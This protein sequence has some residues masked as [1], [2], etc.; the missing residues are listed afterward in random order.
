MNF[1]SYLTIGLI[2]YAFLIFNG[3]IAPPRS[4]YFSIGN[5]IDK[6]DAAFQG[7]I[8]GKACGDHHRFHGRVPVGQV[9]DVLVFHRIK[10]S[11][12]K[13]HLAPG[14]H[15][16]LFRNWLIVSWFFSL[17]SMLVNAY[18]TGQGRSPSLHQVLVTGTG[19][20]IYKFVVAILLT[21]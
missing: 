15:P 8:P 1:F 4:E 17:P 21:P 9:L 7:Y 20:Y 6:P 14:K 11:P 13:K 2:S 5:G 12:A 3:A 16:R 10:K 18:K 19:N